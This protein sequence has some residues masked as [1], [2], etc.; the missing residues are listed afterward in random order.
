MCYLILD[1]L[2]VWSLKAL[3]LCWIWY[4]SFKRCHQNECVEGGV[5][6]VECLWEKRDEQECSQS[7]KTSSDIAACLLTNK[8]INANNYQIYTDFLAKH[9]QILHRERERGDRVRA[10]VLNPFSHHPPPPIRPPSSRSS[11]HLS[12]CFRHVVVET[13]CF[14][15]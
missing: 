3:W 14:A 5:N 2:Y 1:Q 9:T 10:V 12:T 15:H 7:G 11:L 4:D 8:I 13:A 6:C